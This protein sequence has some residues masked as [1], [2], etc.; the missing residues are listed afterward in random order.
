MKHTFMFCEEKVASFPLQKGCISFSKSHFVKTNYSLHY[1]LFFL[2][3][4]WN[5][6]NYKNLQMGF[7][8]ISV[9]N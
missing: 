6:L 5:V 3:K 4:V 8:A 2:L 9:E 1:I 7:E